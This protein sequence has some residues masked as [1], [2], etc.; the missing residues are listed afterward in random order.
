MLG[1][2]GRRE[3]GRELAVLWICRADDASLTEAWST[4]PC[5]DFSSFLEHLSL[6]LEM[7]FTSGYLGMHG[8]RRLLHCCVDLKGRR[9]NYKKITDGSDFTAFGRDSRDMN[10]GHAHTH[11]HTYITARS[12]HISKAECV[13]FSALST[14]KNPSPPLPSFSAAATITASMHHVHSLALRHP[15]PYQAP[16]LLT[17]EDSSISSSTCHE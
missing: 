5:I 8:R 9:Y 15:H 10:H 16:S 14:S 2:Y 12:F 7:T 17:P 6:P 13:S 11:T 1:L 4:A 3:E